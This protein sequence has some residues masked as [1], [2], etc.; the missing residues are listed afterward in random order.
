[1]KK[2]KIHCPKKFLKEWRKLSINGIIVQI[3]VGKSSFV[4]CRLIWEEDDYPYLDSITNFYISEEDESYL[5]S[6][7]INKSFICEM[8]FI[9]DLVTESK[10][11]E[12]IKDRIRKF[13]RETE[14][15]GM[16]KHNDKDILWDEYFWSND[17][18]KYIDS[19]F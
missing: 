4:R 10:Q 6:F 7:G 8:D 17:I 5:K 19:C 12:A 2:P 1:M 14:A 3:P 9:C 11:Y 16:K 18:K 13:I 15:Y